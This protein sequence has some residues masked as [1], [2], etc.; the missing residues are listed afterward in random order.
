MR[1]LPEQKERVETGPTKFGDDWCGVF[2]RG[3]NAMY[4][5]QM[6]NMLL[7]GSVKSSDVIMHA[8]ILDLI[9]LLKSCQE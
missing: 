7:N 3:D 9:E 8:T 5:A 6:L 1:N 4:Y 2:I